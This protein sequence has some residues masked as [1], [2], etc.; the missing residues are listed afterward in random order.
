MEYRQVQMKFTNEMMKIKSEI[1]NNFESATSREWLETNGIGGFANGTISGANS[2]RYHGI[3]TAATKPPLGR[4]TMLSKFEETLIIDG[5]S[6]ELSSNQYPGAI[7]PEGYKY[8]KSF[9]LAPFPRWIYEVGGIE[10][11]KS[12]FMVHGQNS[13]VC[14]WSVVKQQAEISIELKPLL[15]FVDYHSL[16]HETA[17]FNP[18]FEVSETGD[19]QAL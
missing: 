9:A 2:R 14:Q 1:C 8:I 6:Y 5:K 10:I 18:N 16:Q 4:I 13:T 12:I 17:D 7:N 3:L 19:Y 15:S 11:E